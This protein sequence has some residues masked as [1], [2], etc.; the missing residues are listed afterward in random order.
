M[1]ISKYVGIPFYEGANAA[2]AGASRSVFAIGIIISGYA[3]QRINFVCF[4]IPSFSDANY[5]WL[6]L[7]SK[8]GKQKQLIP[9]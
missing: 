8:R 2:T 4:A 7:V 1:G 6:K 5:L 9:V 3:K